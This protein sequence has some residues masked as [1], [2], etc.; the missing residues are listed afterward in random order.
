MYKKIDKA[1][2]DEEIL[3]WLGDMNFF[4]PKNIMPWRKRSLMKHFKVHDFNEISD[5]EKIKYTLNKLG[6]VISDEKEF[7]HRKDWACMDDLIG[8]S[9]EILHHPVFKI[10]NQY[11]MENY[12]QKNDSLLFCS[13]SSKKP[14][15]KAVNY[16]K[17]LKIENLDTIVMSN[18]GI[19]PINKENDV[20]FNYPFRYYNWDHM[21][22]HG[23]LKQEEENFMYDCAKKFLIKYHYKKVAFLTKPK[24]MYDNYYNVYMRLKKDFPEI[25]FNFLID[26]DMWKQLLLIFKEDGLTGLRMFQNKQVIQKLTNFIND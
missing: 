24:H 5:E 25:K 16:R 2:T 8:E 1:L 19:I 18:S 20:S 23:I 15:S 4:K 6:N 10:A 9:I 7:I 11:I 3:K 17:Y 21:K 13:C 22:E 12:K 14:Y 26:E